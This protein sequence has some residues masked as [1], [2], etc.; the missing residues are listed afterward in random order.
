MKRRNF[1]KTATI[2]GAGIGSLSSLTKCSEDQ[3]SKKVMYVKPGEKASSVKK[4]NNDFLAVEIFDDASVKIVD[5]KNGAN[6][7]M[8]PVAVQDKGRIEENNVWMRGERTLMEQY[9]GRFKLKQEGSVFKVTLCNQDYMVQGTFTCKIF[10]ENEWLR[11][12]ILEV[13]NDIPSL[14]FP[15]PITSD[16]ILI[17]HEIGE[18]ISRDTA[19]IWYR[20][21]Y[22]FHAHLTMH[23]IG[24]LKDEN[25]WIGIFDDDVVD[26]GAMVVNSAVAPGWMRSMEQW[27][28]KYAIRYKFIR[29]GY[30][31]VAKEYRQYLK[32]TGRL[33]TLKEKIAETPKLKSMLGGRTLSYFQAWP[34]IDPYEAENYN[35]TPEQR[36]KWNFDGTIV[37]FT[38]QDVMKSLE[39][40]KKKGF[41]N[42]MMILRGWI[43]GGYDAS[44]PDIWPPEPKLGNLDELKQLLDQGENVITGLHDNYQD[45][46]KDYPSFPEGINR[47]PQ[48]R[49]MTGGFWAGGQAYILNS[50][51]SVA[52]AKRNWKDIAMLGSDAYFPD[53]A[54]ASKLEQSYEKGN[55]QTKLQDYN[56]KRELLAFFKEQGQLVGSEKGSDFVADICDWFEN[57]HSRI[58]GETIPL[59]PLVF[60]D[61]AFI[62]RYTSFE[63]GSAYPKWLE[64]MLWGYQLQF[65]MTPEFGNVN[66]NAGSEKIGFGANK[67]D[68][69]LFTSTYHVDRWHKRIGLE[70]MTNHRFMTD[71]KKVEETTFGN[72][73]KIIVNFD[74]NKRIVNGDVIKGH[75]YKIIG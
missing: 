60:H 39:Y 42:G 62:S 18:M 47:D 49:L 59:W 74:S 64:D 2:A 37:D 70:E 53:T 44:H 9:P 75:N 29:G 26:A 45:M 65:F 35:F 24:G 48:G 6:W 61:V 21:F 13:S 73:L 23:W 5:K 41:K 3:S 17:P 28:A 27:D 43:N 63:P 68:D 15:P 55:R 8:G 19:N 7:Q 69:E 36:K 40:A 25:G 12:Q 30:V 31:D 11:Y 38:H 51:N 22:S 32:D 20:K 46:Y 54:A 16:A 10:L 67:M 56:Y 33:K 66:P 34:S 4:M 1:L 52:Y 57:R 72:G 71:D 50:R 14:V 58:E